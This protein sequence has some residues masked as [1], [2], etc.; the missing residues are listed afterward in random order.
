MTAVP[1]LRPGGAV[2]ASTLNRIAAAAARGGDR[3][4]VP[5]RP[6]AR[7]PCVVRAVIIADGA[8]VFPPPSGQAGGS[9]A[10]LPSD[11][12]YD[13][14]PIGGALAWGF[15]P[16]DGESM[17]LFRGL[18]PEMGRPVRDDEAPIHP[19]AEGDLCE[20]WLLPADGDP[21]DQG[22]S[23]FARVALSIMT[24]APAYGCDDGADGGGATP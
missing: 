16:P 22:A 13:V 18:T 24:E 7:V 20:V 21:V 12:G 23:A 11:I 10:H 1:Q 4:A 5:A 17:P 14:D 6:A 9:D 3:T 8:E 19:A 15:A 2:T